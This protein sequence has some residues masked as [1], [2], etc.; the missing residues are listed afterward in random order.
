MVG[1][2]KDHSPHIH[3]VNS[4]G[5]RSANLEFKGKWTLAYGYITSQVQIY[6]MLKA[7]MSSVLSVGFYNFYLPLD[8]AIYRDCTGQGDF[9]YNAIENPMRCFPSGNKLDVDSS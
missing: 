8:V 2:L 7:L 9:S 5:S 1:V 4:L 3:L 6:L